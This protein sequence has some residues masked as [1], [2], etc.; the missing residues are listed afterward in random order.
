MRLLVEKSTQRRLTAEQAA[1]Q[2][3]LNMS[4]DIFFSLTNPKVKHSTSTA[5]TVNGENSSTPAD[6]TASGEIDSTP[7]NGGEAA[8]QRHLNMSMEITQHQQV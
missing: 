1:Q 3:H 8:Q 5:R 2:R 6:D 7:F 4:M